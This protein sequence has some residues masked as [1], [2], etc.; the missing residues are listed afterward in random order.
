MRGCPEEIRRDCGTNFTKAEKE[1]EAIEEW[2]EQKIDGFC[3]TECKRPS[4]L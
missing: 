1:L 3:A 4:Q 2:N